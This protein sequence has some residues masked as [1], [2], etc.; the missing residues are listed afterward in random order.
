GRFGRYWAVAGLALAIQVPLFALLVRG[1]RAMPGLETA[2]AVPYVANVLGGVLV[3][4][5][6]FAVHR[7]WTFRS[8]GAAPAGRVATSRSWKLVPFFEGHLRGTKDV[9]NLGS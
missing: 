7:I 6:N 2:S 8:G 3:F 5:G 4:V 9:L 1:L